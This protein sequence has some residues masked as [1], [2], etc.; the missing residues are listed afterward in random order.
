MAEEGPEEDVPVPRRRDSWSLKTIVEDVAGRPI[1]ELQEPGRPVHP[2]L[3][4]K[5]G[6]APEGAGRAGRPAGEPTEGEVD[7]V[8]RFSPPLVGAI[9]RESHGREYEHHSETIEHLNRIPAVVGPGMPSHPPG[10]SRRPER[11][12]LHYLL[13][14][15]DRLSDA[16]LG[17]L[18]HAVNEELLHRQERRESDSPAATPPK[19]GSAERRAPELPPLSVP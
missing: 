2:Y 17:Y 10:P 18:A 7:P 13:L 5:I 11:I 9:A 4:T 6:H 19:E 16:S 3:R 14:H 15:L 1:E 12:Y 8:A